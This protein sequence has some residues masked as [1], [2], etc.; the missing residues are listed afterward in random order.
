[1]NR[2]YLGND[3]LLFENFDRVQFL[4]AFL[5]AHNHLAECALAENFEEFE[6]LESLQREQS[7][8]ERA[9]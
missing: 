3:D 2:S 1:M 7:V 8:E 4:R 9:A 5:L 6:V